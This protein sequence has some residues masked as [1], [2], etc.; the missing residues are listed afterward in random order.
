MALLVSNKFP[1]L[2]YLDGALAETE[3]PDIVFEELAVF[4]GSLICLRAISV[5]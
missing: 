3:I 1:D 2:Q 4:R 5:Q